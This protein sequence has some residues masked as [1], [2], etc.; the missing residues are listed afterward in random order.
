VAL[1]TASLLPKL[2]KTQTLPHHDDGELT[3]PILFAVTIFMSATLL[4]MVQPMVGKM[5]LPLLGGSPAAWNTCMVFFQTL[6][7]LGYLYT[8][9]MTSRFNP[10]SQTSIHLLVICAAL[11]WLLMMSLLS[12]KGSPVAVF[13]SLAPQGSAYPIFGV[14]LLLSVAIGLPF[15]VISTSAPLLQKWFTFTGHESAK[16]PYFLYAASNCGSLISLLGYPIFIEPQFR[17]VEQAWIWT[18][19]F[20]VLAVL[21]FFCAKAANNPL[22]PVVNKPK[23]TEAELAAEAAAQGPPPSWL[24]RLR[25]LGL[26]FVPSSLMLGVTFHMTTDI[27]SVPLLW[28]I[29][30]ALYLLTFIIAYAKLPEWFRPVIGNLSPVMTLLL[31][32]VLISGAM[33]KFAFYSLVIH[34]VVYFFTALL[35]HSELARAR[36][37]PKYL[38]EYFLW[39]SVGG[40]LGGLFNALIAPIVFP[41]DYE[42]PIAIAIGAFFVPVLAVPK[43][44]KHLE[45]GDWKK[46]LALLSTREAGWVL[47][48][49]IPV[50]L[51]GFMFLVFYCYEHTSWFYPAVE[52]SANFI[53]TSAARIKL[54]YSMSRE[55]LT[56]L[57]LYALPCMLCFFFI[58]RPLR[59]GLCVTAVLFVCYFRGNQAESVERT[60]RSYFGIMKIE[61]YEEYYKPFGFVYPAVNDPLDEDGK[62]YNKVYYHPQKFHK[63]LHGTTLHGVQT[64]GSWKL[65]GRDDLQL[66]M[67][68]SPWEAFAMNGLMTAWDFKQEPLTYYHRTGPVGAIFHRLRELDPQGHIGMVG[69]GTGS[70]SCYARP[71]QKLTYY[72]IDKHVVDIVEKGNY[73]SYVNDAKKRGAEV[74]IVLGD[75]RLQLDQS[76]DKYALLL[77]DAFSS[78]SIPIHLLTQQS[79]ELY[80]TRLTDKGLLALHISN[81]YIDLEPVVARLAEAT[82]MKCRIFSDDNEDF[83]G[84]T[85]SSWVVLANS[86]ETLGDEILGNF[87][88]DRFGAIAGGFGF[89][90]YDNRSYNIYVF[91]W[92]KLPLDPNVEVWTDDFSDVLRVMRMEQIRAIRKAFG[93]PVSKIRGE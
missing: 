72:E 18:A 66:L 63:L 89:D 59:F 30:L 29:P 28:V 40:M 9:R 3:V 70:V 31:V 19:G 45:N 74:K 54:N 53:N 75:A 84:K 27:A 23:Q 1:K 37:N 36:P 79:L 38:T 71:G 69:L 80:K 8:H 20:G 14:L 56:L 25:W 46:P 77:I 67:A 22:R 39:I 52:W 57:P 78:D 49:I 7:L 11:A 17:L 35:M 24:D 68:T 64:D 44:A 76:E 2:L 90:I 91:P 43:L 60:D 5:I 6:L 32:F 15:L 92:K 50:A 85:R 81:R 21:V 26:A 10:K 61:K 73:F 93:L 42:Y 55:T 82:G 51:A 12:P 16:D 65:P 88:D 33:G 48:A 41:I 13:H 47:D 87:V 86:D 62:P 4:F 34:L 58:D 83:S